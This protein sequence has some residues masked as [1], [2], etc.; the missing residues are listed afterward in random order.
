M[1]LNT[2]RLAPAIGM[3]VIGLDLSKGLDDAVL[4]GVKDLFNDNA[5]LLF[6]DQGP[7]EEQ[8]IG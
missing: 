6:R 4:G 8:H 3:E 5:I 1:S 2:R 7:T